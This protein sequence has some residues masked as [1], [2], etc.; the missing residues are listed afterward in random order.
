MINL[1]ESPIIPAT[2]RLNKDP[3]T[4]PFQLIVRTSIL[5]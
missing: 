3:P 1:N 4:Y 5:L 2:K